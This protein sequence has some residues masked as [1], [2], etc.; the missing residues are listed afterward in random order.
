LNDDDVA[1]FVGE[2]RV[3]DALLDVGHPSTQGPFAMPDYYFELRHQQVAAL[4]AALGVF[5]T[6]GAEFERLSGRR[7]RA[8][9]HYE[10]EGSERALVCM[11]STAGTAKDAGV[12][13]VQIRSF[14]PF[15]LADVR[16][17]LADLSE[18]VVLDRADSPGGSPPLFAEVAATL[19][20]SGAQVRSHVYGLGGREVHPEDIRSIVAGSEPRYV[21]LRGEPCPV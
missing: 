7:Y 10:L 4:Q 5:E 8:V 18:I 15:P 6:L 1:A 20:G 14:R 19:S 16:G 11:G 9:E 21:G 3:P 2:Y 17:A 12:P 13:V